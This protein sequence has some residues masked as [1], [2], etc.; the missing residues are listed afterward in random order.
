MISFETENQRINL[1]FSYRTTADGIG[2]YVSM[3]YVPVVYEFYIDGIVF[4]RIVWQNNYYNMKETDKTF[5]DYFFRFVQ[6]K[7]DRKYIKHL[8]RSEI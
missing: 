2:K 4:T 5:L 8:K 7:F 1:S 6:C 3:N